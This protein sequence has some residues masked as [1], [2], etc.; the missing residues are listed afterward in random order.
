[1]SLDMTGLSISDEESLELLK[2]SDPLIIKALDTIGITSLTQVQ[3][4]TLPIIRNGSD[5]LS[6]AKTGTG[7]TL[8]FLIPTL[9]KL[10]RSDA[11]LSSSVDS[12]RAIVLSSTR[13]LA[14]QVR[15]IFRPD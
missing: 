3:K 13:E 8:A 10:L 9:E 11:E 6:K 1:M 12:I 7:K 15:F 4:E 2:T 5:V 14:Q